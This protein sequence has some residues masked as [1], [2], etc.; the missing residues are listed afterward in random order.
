MLLIASLR[1]CLH[2]VLCQIHVYI[3]FLNSGYH[4]LEH[5]PERDGPLSSMSNSNVSSSDVCSPTLSGPGWVSIA[6][7][8]CSITGH[9]CRLQSLWPNNRWGAPA[10]AAVLYS[11]VMPVSCNWLMW[12]CRT[13]LGTT[14]TAYVKGPVCVLT[15]TGNYFLSSQ[16]SWAN[17]FW[18]TCSCQGTRV[19]FVIA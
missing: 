5:S 8:W 13:V 16:W 3:S 14:C 17:T 15:T 18:P 10:V 7:V 11:A 2:W 12:Q 4:F 19:P 6:T 1:M 9:R